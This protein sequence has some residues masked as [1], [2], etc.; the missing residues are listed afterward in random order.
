MDNLLGSSPV[1]SNKKKSFIIAASLIGTLCVIGTILLFTKSSYQSP[2]LIQMQLEEEEF[3]LFISNYNK[4]YTANEYLKRLQVFRDNLIFIRMQNQIENDWVLGVNQFTDL[5]RD[6]FKAMYTP[7]KFIRSE[8][9]QEQEFSSVQALPTFV[10]WRQQGAVTPVKN[11]GACGSCW[12]FSTTGA[13]EGLWKI[14]GNS[15]VSLS[16]QELMD[17]SVSF[18]NNGCN[19]G[20]MDYAFEFIMKNGITLESNYPYAGV[21]GTCNTTAEQLIA[22]NITNY[23]NVQTENPTA[24]Q[25]AVA[26][27]PVSV[28]VE[29][30]QYVWQYYKGGII[31]KNCGTELDHGV[32][33]VGYNTTNSPPYWIVKN[34]WGAGWGE[35]GYVRIQISAAKGI[36]GINI[37]PS[38]PTL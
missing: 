7:N 14:S 28:A 32:L 31:S 1:S 26:Q 9:R 16:E 22:A 24:L 8:R 18:G 38:Y 19:G 33:V 4:V 20:L 2:V 15:L 13:V 27:Q 11:Q 6:E 36:C 35:N 29:A 34:S 37:E 30:N 3:K 25:S 21:Q 23:V 5:T 12:A 17:C 10:D